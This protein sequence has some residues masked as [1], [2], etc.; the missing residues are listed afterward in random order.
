M[1]RAWTYLVL[2][3]PFVSASP[4]EVKKTF[5]TPLIWK[6]VGGAL[7]SALDPLNREQPLDV[8]DT[9]CSL[10]EPVKKGMAAAACGGALLAQTLTGL[11]CPVSYIQCSHSLC[12]VSQLSLLSFAS[13]MDPAL[14]TD[15]CTSSKK[16]L[17]QVPKTA[18]DL[19]GVYAD[20]ATAAAV[21]GLLYMLQGQQGMVSYN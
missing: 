6:L 9:F 5:E 3:A 13:S 12:M 8:C 20:P 10:G 4:L 2:L 14:C 17:R 19:T 1:F 15:I 18:F 11:F 21:A 7:G 16:T